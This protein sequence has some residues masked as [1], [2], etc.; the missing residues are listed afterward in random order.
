MYASLM[1]FS[2]LNITP[3]PEDMFSFDEMSKALDEIAKEDSTATT[4]KGFGKDAEF[5]PEQETALWGIFRQDP[6]HF[7]EGAKPQIASQ[8]GMSP[9][10]VT[11]CTK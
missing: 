5:T 9:A 1:A 10:Q 11:V 6:Y 8:L 3:R 4:R 2:R 7:V